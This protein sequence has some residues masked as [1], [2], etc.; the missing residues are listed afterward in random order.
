[1]RDGLAIRVHCL[2]CGHIG[3][4]AAEALRAKHPAYERLKL[5]A[6]R[7]RCSNC[8]APGAK[9]VHMWS[10]VN[11]VEPTALPRV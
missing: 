2:P 7:F 9:G 6:Y 4:V 3:T 1:L 10:I 5:I 8:G 11:L